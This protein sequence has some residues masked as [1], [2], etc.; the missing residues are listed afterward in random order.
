MEPL[1]QPAA[2]AAVTSRPC[3]VLV[4][5]ATVFLYGMERAVIETFE[6]LRPEVEAHLVVSYTNQRLHLPLLDEIRRSGLSYAFLS[7]W[8]D[9][10]GIGKPHSLR[11]S[12]EMANAV[13]RGNLDM[14]RNAK[15]CDI[16]YLPSPRYVWLALGVTLYFRLRRR[17]VVLDV[18]DLVRKWTWMW[19]L[20]VRLATDLIH[21]SEIGYQRLVEFDP[22]VAQKRN[23]VLPIRVASTHDV[24]P[25]T[26]LMRAF[27]G[28]RNIVFAG[29]VSNYKGIDLLLEAFKSIAREF[30][31]AQLHIFGGCANPEEFQL[32]IANTEFQGRVR[33]WGFRTDVRDAIRLAY[34]YVHPS[35]P[36]RFQESFGRGVVEAM[37]TGVPS[38]AFPSGALAGII[39]DQETGL[40]CQAETAACL[41]EALGR[42][43]RD[44]AFCDA[45]GRAARKRYDAEY[46]D[47]I[48]RDGWVRFFLRGCSLH[49]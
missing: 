38:V 25:S 42:F 14:A 21:H 40:L 34:V 12:L 1:A 16:L 41:S 28:H 43:L 47:Q 27:E 3:R 18:Y 17:R 5:F 29:Q 49:G 26:D 23:V 2:S 7:D 24:Q 37:S 45:C 33:H 8:Q 48:I 44:P 20:A 32:E 9:W 30:S 22:V 39:V 13:I 11:E 4:N 36:T 19:K 46:S 15:N 10:P 6:L 35:P 31:D